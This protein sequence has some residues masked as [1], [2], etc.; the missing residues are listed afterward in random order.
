MIDIYLIDVI[1]KVSVTTNENGLKS[2][3]ESSNINARVEDYNRY[4]LG[5]N[6]EEV[7]ASSYITIGGG[8]TFSYGDK[9]KIV[10]KNGNAY[11]DA[12]KKFVVKKISTQETFDDVYT[13][14]YI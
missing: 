3:V 12:D 11:I 7:F 2:E 4:I 9:L 5:Q 8:V 14:L 1:R 13:E 10:S 6:G